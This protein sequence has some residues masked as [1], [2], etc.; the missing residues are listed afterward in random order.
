[1]KKISSILLIFLIGCSTIPK[2]G[3][4]NWYHKRLEEIETAYQNGEITKAEYIHLKNETDQV[5]STFRAGQ[6]SAP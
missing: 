1:M 5:R 4:K 3:T 2:A 6:I